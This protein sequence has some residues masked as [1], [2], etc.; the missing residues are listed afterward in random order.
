MIDG[1]FY[2]RF[3]GETVNDF[4][5]RIA[6]IAASSRT[7]TMIYGGLSPLPGTTTIMPGR[8]VPGRVVSSGD[9]ATTDSAVDLVQQQSAE[10]Q[11]A[12]ID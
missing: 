10:Q 7:R 12:G 5:V 9:A 1:E 6:G 11:T 2:S 4:Q 8:L 3:D